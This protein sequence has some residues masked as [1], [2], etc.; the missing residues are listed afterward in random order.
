MVIA[1]TA[2]VPNKYITMFVWNDRRICVKLN[3]GYNV[4]C[5]L[6]SEETIYALNKINGVKTQKT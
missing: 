4:S 6:Q 3:V 2:H 5:D 1:F